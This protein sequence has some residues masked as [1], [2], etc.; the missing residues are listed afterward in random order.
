MRT[1]KVSMTR[2]INYI[3]SLE[4]CHILVLS[5]IQ[6]PLPRSLSI[7]STL[8]YRHASLVTALL[9][10]TLVSH[11]TCQKIN[12][13]SSFSENFRQPSSAALPEA[14]EP[15]Y[16]YFWE[17]IP[18]DEATTTRWHHL[19]EDISLCTSAAVIVL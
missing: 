15:S 2:L 3:T 9:L 8:A 6:L 13:T 1:S 12:F 16:N 11:Y 7:D 14:R 10:A 5:E 18:V 4:N 17:L 19:I